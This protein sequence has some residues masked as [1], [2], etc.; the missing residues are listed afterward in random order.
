MI[1]NLPEEYSKIMCDGG[2]R[3]DIETRILAAS[4]MMETLNEQ[5]ADPIFN[6]D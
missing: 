3:L 5:G 2:E 4:Q 1:L 6:K